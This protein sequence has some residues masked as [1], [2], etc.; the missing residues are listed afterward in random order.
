M[1]RRI[2]AAAALAGGAVLLAYVLRHRPEEARQAGVLI[3][4]VCGGLLLN[5]VSLGLRHIELRSWVRNLACVVG[6]ILLAGTLAIWQWLGQHVPGLPTATQPR[7]DP[8]LRAALLRWRDVLLWLSV[9]VGYVVVSLA[10]LPRPRRPG[11]AAGKAEQPA[12]EPPALEAAGA[13]RPSTEEAGGPE[14]G[15]GRPG[16]EPGPTVERG[17][18]S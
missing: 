13:E 17:E 15:T 10:L 2:A 11:T 16:A 3:G 1:L 7:I 9:C 6:L 14:P 8:E 18:Q 5:L 12:P 4:L